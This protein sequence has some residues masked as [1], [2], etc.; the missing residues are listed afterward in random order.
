M[1][2]VQLQ[3]VTDAF[4][5]MLI[6]TAGI[7]GELSKDE[8]TENAKIL[9]DWIV[10]FGVDNDEDGDV[11]F[12]DFKSAVSRAS[13]TYISCENR[14]EKAKI[15]LRCI[16]FIKEEVPKDIQ[17][18]IIDKLRKMTSADGDVT[19]GEEGLVDKI[20]ELMLDENI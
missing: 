12:D 7:D 8:S 10:Y 9:M 1:T 15:L 14:K 6:Y 5:Y 2:E 18:L 19:V 17:L 4:A 13:N 11:D 3:S 16:V 20:E